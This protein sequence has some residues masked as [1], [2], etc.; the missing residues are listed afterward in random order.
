MERPVPD[1]EPPLPKLTAPAGV[2]RAPR[3][4]PEEELR[5]LRAARSNALLIGPTWATDAA[6]ELVVADRREHISFW[7]PAQP[8][9]VSPHTIVVIRDVG[10]LAQHVQGRWVAALNR[11]PHDQ[12]P[13]VISTNSFS[14][15]PLVGRGAF[16][17]SLYYR[18]NCVLVDFRSTRLPQ[19]PEAS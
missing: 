16:L 11:C 13:Q 5:I 15:F 9:R 8:I 7:T 4:F 18:L 10:L 1:R 3:A 14:V 2:H 12:L 17:D 6:I 19:A